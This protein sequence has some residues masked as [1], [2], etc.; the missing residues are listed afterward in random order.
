MIT[1]CQ[2]GNSVFFSTQKCILVLLEKWKQAIDS[3][4][5]FDALLTDISKA[6]DCLDYELLIEKLNVY[7]FTLPVL[8]LVHDY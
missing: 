4:Q 5:M 7:G 6:F 1:F 8:K 2:K 3:S